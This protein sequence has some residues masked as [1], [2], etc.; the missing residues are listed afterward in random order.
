V[1][2]KEPMWLRLNW[3]VPRAN[4][5]AKV[6]S[7]NPLPVVRKPSLFRVPLVPG[8]ADTMRAFAEIRVFTFGNILRE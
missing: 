3:P 4:P 5:R 7:G 1:R 6:V 2:S 8:F